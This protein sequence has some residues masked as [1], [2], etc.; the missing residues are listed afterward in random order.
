VLD[1]IDLSGTRLAGSDLRGISAIGAKMADADLSHALLK[2]AK[3]SESL[4]RAKLTGVWWPGAP[5][6]RADLNG[7]DLSYANLQGG[8]FTEASLSNAVLDG[9]HMRQSTLIGTG[10]EA[11][12]LR[13]TDLAGSIFE[14]PPGQTPP[15]TD[16]IVAPYLATLRFKDSPHALVALR[17]A[18]QAA[19]LRQQERAITFSIEH[20]RRL[21]TAEPERSLKYWFLELPTGY[22]LAPNRPLLIVLAMVVLCAIGYYLTIEMGQRAGVIVIVRTRQ[23]DRPEDYKVRLCRLRVGRRLPQGLHVSRWHAARTAFALSSINALNL[24][25]QWLDAGSWLRML[26]RKNYDLEAVGFGRSLSGL[27]SLVS[28]YMMTL[29]LLMYF[30][31]PFE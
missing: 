3:L 31:N 11:V 21:Q 14:P 17:E 7:A 10:L 15:I 24:K 27:Q 6:A 25:V 13:R 19:G 18:F 20:E 22:G 16:L 9:A 26:R 1:E 8:D 4:T 5:L 30:G 12:H 28:M 23:K 29:W 2:G